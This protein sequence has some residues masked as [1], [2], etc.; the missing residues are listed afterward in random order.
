LTHK[1]PELRDFDL[2]KFS[3]ANDKVYPVCDTQESQGAEEE[4]AE[5]KEVEEE[6][7]P[8]PLNQL[9]TALSR[10][11]Q[12]QQSALPEDDL[13]ISYAEIMSLV[14]FN[15]NLMLKENNKNILELWQ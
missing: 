1:G 2:L 11:A 4:S 9:I 8:D 6:A 15:N 5:K 12:E 10:G 13:Y 3:L 7:K 14:R